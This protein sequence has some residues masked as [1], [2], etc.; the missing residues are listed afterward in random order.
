MAKVSFPLGE[1]GKSGSHRFV[2]RRKSDRQPFNTS[3][4]G[5]LG[6]YEV[7]NDANYA[8]YKVACAEQGT[9]G[10]YECTVPANVEAGGAY[11]WRFIE[12]V[13]N[14]P[15]GDVDKGGGTSG[16]LLQEIRDAMKLAPSA[17]AA[18]ANSVD[19]KLDQ[20]DAGGLL[21]Q[22][23]TPVD[24]NTGGADNLRYLDLDTDAAIDNGVI[25]AYLK[26]DYDIGVYQLR[27]QAVTDVNGRWVAPMYL[28]AGNTYVF[29]YEKPGT[30]GPTKKE[31]A[32]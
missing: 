3:L 16:V 22:G 8:N 5:G 23:D 11:E 6:A 32:V 10:N 17:G 7:W 29:V 31:Q 4:S 25:R 1:T 21:G 15:A 20:I 24:H 13:T 30:Y 14:T 19:Y 12:N 18:A 27:G 9:S 28:N 2:F 26:T